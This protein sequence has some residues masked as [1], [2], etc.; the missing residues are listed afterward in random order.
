M[1]R[2]PV[3]FHVDLDAFYASVEQLDHP[4]LRGKPVI[5]GARPGHRGVVAACSYE[6]RA[7]GVHSAM[8]ISEAS[9]RC[10]HAAFRPV[11]MAR[12]Q[13]MSR[14]VMAIFEH[15][16]PELQQI[17]VDEA[18]LDMTGT[19][20]LFGPPAETAARL[21]RE[22]RDSLGLVTSVGIG[23]SR[24]IA[25]LA[26]AWSKPD[27]LHEVKPGE[28]AEFVE[29]LSLQDLWGVGGK[30]LRRL[31][32]FGI[33]TVAQLR[34]KTAAELSGLFGRAAGD[35]LHTVSRGIDPGIYSGEAQSH[36]VSNETTFG[37][38]VTDREIIESTVLELCHG[39][40]FR[41]LRG[42]LVSRTVTLK[43]R[44][45]DFTTTTVRRTLSEP[46][47][48]TESLYR[49]ALSMLEEKWDGAREIR[50]IGVGTAQVEGKDDARQGDLFE[51]R[52]DRRRRVEE[53]A[54]DVNSRFGKLGLTRARLLK[55]RTDREAQDRE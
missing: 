9:K 38:D 26:S 28:E 13:E 47:A 4:R 11:R 42:G 34:E 55:P 52:D 21:K 35:Y 22:V 17:S 32:D 20:R 39:V 6:A 5:V 10:P 15:Y 7:Y 30:T 36:S 24:Y 19:E 49:T 50:L 43:L 25:K 54:L 3:F 12:Y 29:S 48:S 46:V 37:H 41:L 16:T 27:G 18:F 40:V 45:S 44:F 23:P 33:N 8:P 14:S 1:T 31:K 53:A 51:G 2:M